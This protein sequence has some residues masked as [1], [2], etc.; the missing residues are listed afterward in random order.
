[1]V[2][3][4]SSLWTL[5][6]RGRWRAVLTELKSSIKIS[7][8]GEFRRKSR[9]M[10]RQRKRQRSEGCWW[11]KEKK[12]LKNHNVPQLQALMHS[13]VQGKNSLREGCGGLCDLWSL[14][15]T[16]PGSTQGS[17]GHLIFVIFTR[18]APGILLFYLFSFL[19]RAPQIVYFSGL[20]KTGPTLA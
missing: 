7:G 2:L 17:C 14:P 19:Q 4:R 12:W 13:H 10:V 8:H 9:R 16:C 6:D 11:K 3:N 18:T 15:L 1:M 20:Q 5:S